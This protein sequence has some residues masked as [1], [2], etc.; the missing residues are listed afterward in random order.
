MQSVMQYDMSVAP[1]PSAPRA[2]FN[3]SH[4]VKTTGDMDYIHPF[5]VEDV[6][7]GDTWNVNTALFARLA[8]P[9]YPLMDN[10]F[11]DIHYFWI[12]MRMVW[13]NSRKFFG[14][15][16]DPGDSISYTIPTVTATATTGYTEGSIFDHFALPT[17]IQN[18]THSVLPLRC[19]NLVYNEWFR[20]QNIIDSV[21]TDDADTDTGAPATNYTLLK[22]GKRHDYF[23][24]C[25]VNPQKDPATAQ[26]LPLGSK[27]TIVS[28]GAGGSAVSVYSAEDAA[29]RDLRDGT[30][31][32]ANDITLETIAASGSALYA[33]LTNATAATILQLRQAVQI[34][35]LIELDARAGT[36]YNEIVYATY[37]V[38][39]PQDSYKPE[40]LGGGSIP[41]G[42]QQIAQTSND[43]TNGSVG[44]L[45]GYGTAA[46]SNNGFV[47]SFSEHGFIL[48]VWSGRADLTYSQ[49]L[50]KKWTRSTRYDFMHP[51]LQNI[52]D[53]AVYTKELYCSDPATDTGST[54][55]ADNERVFGYQERYADYKYINSKITG[56][57]R[58]NATTSLEAWH[59]SEE[60]AGGAS[61]PTLDQT[62]IESN[63][64]M[65][66]AIVTATEP[67][68]IIDMYNN[69]QV[70]RPMHLYSI[71]GFGDRF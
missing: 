30:G 38:S 5:L 46:G 61:L 62:F 7:P 18:Y 65:D 13:K 63:T 41:I 19:Y 16:E 11:I 3:L 23:T 8:T 25:L 4:G 60:F 57:F 27:A 47:K 40:Y 42:V 54:G 10:A 53:Q 56:L 45:S 22:R 70:A 36:R 28:P 68:L 44:Q 1:T 69:C 66:R 39:P 20:D 33:D 64:P 52:G 21:Y 6:L 55:T 31:S 51:I 58:P 26:A 67:H 2:N 32:T 35:A 37:G 14:E 43:G 9:L 12:P 29:F 59:L 15:Q 34:Q 24:S 17:K 49:G 48:G 50:E 71:P